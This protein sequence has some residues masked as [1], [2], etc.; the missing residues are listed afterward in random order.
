MHPG[1]VGGVELWR[2]WR[3][4]GLPGALRRRAP[5]CLHAELRLLAAVAVHGCSCCYQSVC[6]AGCVWASSAAWEAVEPC[7]MRHLRLAAAAARCCC[8]CLLFAACCC[9]LAASPPSRC[10]C[11]AALGEAKGCCMLGRPPAACM[12]ECWRACR[13]RMAR[14][15]ARSA[16]CARLHVRS[17]HM[18]AAQSRSAHWRVCACACTSACPYTRTHAHAQ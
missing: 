4:R 14:L 1:C 7:R 15:H 2:V 3:V 5:G 18:H 8:R 10:C 9:C 12:A 6:A 17:A 16:R 11:A 13:A